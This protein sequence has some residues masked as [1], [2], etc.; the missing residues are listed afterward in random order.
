MKK[1]LIYLLKSLPLWLGLMICLTGMPTDAAVGTDEPGAGFVKNVSGQ[2]FIERNHK[3]VPAKVKDL[4]QE[5]D[6]LVTG[7]DGSLGVILQDNSVLA[8][9]ANT[10][11]VI[12]TFLFKPAE[13][14]VSFLARITK[15][16]VVYLTGLIAK[17]DRSAVRFET[18]TSVCGVRGTHFA[19]AVREEEL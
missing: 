2:A 13:E 4:L 6:V 17:L 15:G 1:K 19:I 11:L 8:I 18:P 5:G 9:G 16:K 7:T 14:K 3:A 12:S 10:R